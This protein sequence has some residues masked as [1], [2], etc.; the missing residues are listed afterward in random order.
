MMIGATW[1]IQILHGT[2]DKGK[3]W[4]II[5]ETKMAAST[6]YAMFF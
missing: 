1:M 4:I 2:L 6:Y 3:K 5:I